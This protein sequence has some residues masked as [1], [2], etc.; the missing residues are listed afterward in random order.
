MGRRQRLY[1]LLLKDILMKRKR[2]KFKTKQE[3]FQNKV[4]LPRRSPPKPSLPR[5]NPQK[6]PKVKQ[7]NQTKRGNPLILKLQSKLMLTRKSLRTHQQKLLK[8]LNHWRFLLLM[9]RKE[10]PQHP[11]RTKTRKRT[12]IRI[13]TNLPPLIRN[14]PKSSSQNLNLPKSNPQA[15]LKKS[16]NRTLPL[17]RPSQR[18]LPRPCSSRRPRPRSS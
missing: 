6:Y 8:L 7:R 13:R 11:Q 12:K 16:W 14:P 18:R 2:R 10:S 15:Q 1:L 17:R 5:Q 9:K 4:R 3:L